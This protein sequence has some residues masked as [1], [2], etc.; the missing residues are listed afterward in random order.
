MLNRP[1]PILRMF[2]RERTVRFYVD[3]LGFEL[4]GEEGESDGPQFLTVQRD[5]VRIHLSSHHGDGTPGAVVL[6]PVDDVES[7]H[8]ELHSRPYPFM[9]PGIEPRG[10]GR[11][12]TVLD[13]ASNQIRFFQPG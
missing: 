12:V 1:I 11:E 2:D 4:V 5:D 9:H 8:A 13:P 7:L 6:V 3:W 10:I